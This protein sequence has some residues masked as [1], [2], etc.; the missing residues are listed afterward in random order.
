MCGKIRLWPSRAYP[1]NFCA[2]TTCKL[3][4]NLSLKFNIHAVKIARE[5]KKLS[6]AAKALTENH[7]IR[8][9]A[10]HRIATWKYTYHISPAVGGYILV[11]FHISALKFPLPPG[12]GIYTSLIKIPDYP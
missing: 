2:L 10:E 7:G 4:R 11:A 1:D 12:M 8:C 6:S 3:L 9:R 5:E